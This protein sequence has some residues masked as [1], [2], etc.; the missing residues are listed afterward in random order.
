MANRAVQDKFSD[1]E[2][3]VGENG[4][5]LQVSGITFTVDTSIDCDSVN[6]I[7]WFDVNSHSCTTL[8]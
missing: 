7:N 1:G 2:N 6:L 3:A 8:S 5:F 4:A